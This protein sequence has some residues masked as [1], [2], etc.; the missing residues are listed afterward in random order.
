MSWRHHVVD[1]RPLRTSA[2]FRHLWL[3]SAV[4]AMG[5][6][7]ANLAVLLQVWEITRS[8]VWTG[9]IGLAVAVP[10]LVFGLVGGSL[11]DSFDRR[12]VV[13]VSA[14][15][16][17]LAAVA[18]TAQA[19]AGMASVAL[20]LVLVAAE[21]T[22]NALGAPARRT[23]PVR[24]LPTGQVTAGIALQSMAFQGAT[25]V[26]PAVGGLV[27]ARW[28]FS[29]AYALHVVT[30]LVALGAVARLP[31]L[32]P[33]RDEDPTHDRA[34]RRAARGGWRIV[35]ERPVLRGSFLTDLAATVLA[36][37]ISLFPLV[38]ELRFDGNPRTLGLFLSAVAA[39]G[40]G[41]GLL[42][43]LF[44]RVRRAGLLQLG[45]ATTWGVALAGFGFAEQ[46]GLALAFLAVAGAADTVSVVTRSAMVQVET[47]DRFRGRV[48][49]VEHVVGVAGPEVGN[50]R[51]GVVA[52]L[53]SAPTSLVLGGLGAAA[54]VVLVGLRNRP[55]RDYVPPGHGTHH[56]SDGEP[57]AV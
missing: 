17:L 27:L 39:G 14:V 44:T 3:G 26:G 7:V 35:L 12:T 28:G 16:Q 43:G 32:R 34:P 40:L 45:A 15:G 23:F 8:A 6:Q 11:A 53:T 25:L 36:M 29:G 4:G 24:L 10:L 33:V 56:P 41:A 38:N 31:S 50:F 54:T 18:L 48:S 57:A 51:G 19:M 49:S 52:S 21:S 30:A 22:A 1:A 2:A 46:A 42:S 9:T 47:P 55:L 5:M 13:A 20:V 37:P